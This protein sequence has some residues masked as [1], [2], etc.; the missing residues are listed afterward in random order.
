MASVAELERAELERGVAQL[1]RAAELE[2]ERS[3]RAA[4]HG[5]G[6]AYG[7]AHVSV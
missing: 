2:R 6:V 5:A 1:E 4:M 7:R 3:E